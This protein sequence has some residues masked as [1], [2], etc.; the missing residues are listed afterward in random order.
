MSL[1]RW[2]E[3]LGSV[4]TPL[5]ERLGSVLPRALAGGALLLAGWLL[6]RLLRVWVAAGV[7]RLGRLVAWRPVEG[8]LGRVGVEQP[9]GEVVGSVV[10]WGVLV[11]FVAAATDVVGLPVLAAWLGAASTY[12]PRLL[13]AILIVV[14][15]VVAGSLARDAARTAARAARRQ[16][17]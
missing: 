9:P 13:L 17:P 5:G 10:F 8:G 14:A 11:V 7:A 3:T 4:L 16:S 1:D 2:I 6:A 15:G 12:L